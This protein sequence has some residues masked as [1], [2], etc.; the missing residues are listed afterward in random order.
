MDEA[1]TSEILG[2]VLVLAGGNEVQ[3]RGTA[4]L[5]RRFVAD[6]KAAARTLKA[7]RDELIHLDRITTARKWVFP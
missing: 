1:P 4:A 7:L 2:H 6:L 3:Q 5:L